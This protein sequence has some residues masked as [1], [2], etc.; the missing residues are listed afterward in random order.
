MMK[1]QLSQN[2]RYVMAS[3]TQRMTTYLFIV[4]TFPIQSN[5]LFQ[6]EST[7]T[8]ND[9]EGSSVKLEGRKGAGG[10]TKKP[11]GGKSKE[12]RRLESTA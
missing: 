10:Q 1:S 4:S 3:L 6:K 7:T 12:K 11:E 8:K 5:T 9:T 2:G